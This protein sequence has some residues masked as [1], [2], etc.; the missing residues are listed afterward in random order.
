M[1]LKVFLFHFTALL[2]IL[3]HGRLFCLVVQISVIEPD[4]GI[5][6]KDADSCESKCEINFEGF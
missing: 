2:V 5:I 1:S 4:D 3:F 6:S